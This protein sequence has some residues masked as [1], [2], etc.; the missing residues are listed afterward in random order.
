MGRPKQGLYDSLKDD[1]DIII[2]WQGRLER[3]GPLL[4]RLAEEVGARSVLDVGGGT[5]HHAR[6]FHSWGLSVTL[7]DPSRDTLESVRD[8]L[9]PEIALE[10]RGLQDLDGLR[11]HDMVVCLGNTLP[12]VRDRQDFSGA[13]ASLWRVLRPG[14]VLVCHQ[15]NYGPIMADFD[16]HRFM[17]PRGLGEKAL[18]RFFEH[19]PS[20][21]G[22]RFVIMRLSGHSGD[23]T[24]E[25][26]WTHHT[27]VVADD[28]Q[29]ELQ[30]L[31]ASRVAL[32][33]TWDEKPF[34]EAS[35]DALVVVARK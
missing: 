25:Y 9:P 26:L 33:G 13:M 5:G 8:S 29:H 31:R 4:K 22:L 27:P 16:E 17:E 30:R 20:G 11:P 28:Y 21:K 32:H 12:H 34:E 3:E 14:G 2:D 24:T 10:V 35:S 18:F 6:M 19:E 15:L 1:Y 23:Y 7:A